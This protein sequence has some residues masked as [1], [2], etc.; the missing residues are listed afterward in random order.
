M[1]VQKQAQALG[2]ARPTPHRA[3]T[4]EEDRLLRELYGLIPAE[5]LAARLGRGRSVVYN[6]LRALRVTRASAQAARSARDQAEIRR[7]RER[8]SDA[9]D[10]RR[11]SILLAWRIQVIGAEEAAVALGVPVTRLAVELGKAA[12]PGQAAVRRSLGFWEG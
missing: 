12:A 7:L 1:A 8:G 10:E 9:G 4:P 6:R 5:D 11:A 2:L 3:W